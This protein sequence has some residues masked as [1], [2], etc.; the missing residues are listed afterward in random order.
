VE[1]N[2][3]N[4]RVAQRMLEQLNCEVGIAANGEEAI[5]ALALA[6][7]DLVFMDCQMPVMDGFET[8]QVIRESCEA[9]G[10]RI[11]I[12]AMTANAMTGARE[13]CLASGMDDY[14][15]KPVRLEDM[16]A[17]IKRWAGKREASQETE[18]PTS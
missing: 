2:V 13:K 1:D 6:D 12:I 17:A 7:Y 11:P 8:T 3:I 15:S 18:L 14:V 16:A 4:Q 10:Q 5:S 9:D